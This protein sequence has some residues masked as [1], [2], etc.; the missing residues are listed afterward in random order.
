MINHK[1]YARLVEQA[2]KV[3]EHFD[4][5]TYI[6]TTTSW[7]DQKLFAELIVRKCAE[8]ADAAQELHCES[9]SDNILFNMGVKPNA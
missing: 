2:T 4:E 9:I 5:N 1:I 8:I 6:T 3:T 7:F